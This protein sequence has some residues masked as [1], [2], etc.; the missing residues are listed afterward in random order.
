MMNK[1]DWGRLGAALLFLVFVGVTGVIIYGAANLFFT[2]LPPIIGV[3][4]YIIPVI[5]VVVG[6]VAVIYHDMGKQEE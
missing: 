2:V 5:V 3:W 1:I 4:A 6:L